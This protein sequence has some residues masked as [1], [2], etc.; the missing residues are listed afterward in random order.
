MTTFEGTMEWPDLERYSDRPV[1]NTKAVVQQTGIPAP[2]LRAWERR[3][4][5][6]SPKRADNDYR[7]YTERDI[8]LLRW[9][10]DRVENGMSISQAIALYRQ[11]NQD[12]AQHLESDE[13]L[14]SA[15]QGEKQAQEEY[16]DCSVST[17]VHGSA[18]A[19]SFQVMVIVAQ[20]PGQYSQGDLRDIAD[21]LYTVVVEQCAKKREQ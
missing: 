8:V 19:D 17:R 1:F 20:V 5:L 14:V 11:L 2:T 21:S 18:N 12:Q 10:R 16:F 13:V 15:V 6:F 3:Y 4:A 7:L 9:L